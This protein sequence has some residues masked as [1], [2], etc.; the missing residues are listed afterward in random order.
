[1]IL[2]GAGRRYPLSRVTNEPAD[3]A[4]IASDSTAPDVAP[5]AFAENGT[6]LTFGAQGSAGTVL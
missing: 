1:V 4:P 5:F 2:R 6:G 3:A